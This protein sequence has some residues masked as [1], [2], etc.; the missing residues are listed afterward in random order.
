[1]Q[2]NKSNLRAEVDPQTIDMNANANAN[3]IP[4]ISSPD[5]KISEGSPG[6]GKD[7]KPTKINNMN[8][9]CSDHKSTIYKSCSD[10][11]STAQDINGHLLKA[12]PVQNICNIIQIYSG[13]YILNSQAL[14]MAIH[15]HNTRRSNL[16]RG[17]HGMS[18][19]MMLS[20]LKQRYIDEHYY[21][22]VRALRNQYFFK[23]PKFCEE[24]Q[25]LL[26]IFVHDPQY[27]IC[28]HEYIVILNWTLTVEQIVS[29]LNAK[30]CRSRSILR[31]IH[32]I[33]D[34]ITDSEYNNLLYLAINND[35]NRYSSLIIPLLDLGAIPTLD[36][37][38]KALRHT[39]PHRCVRVLSS[40]KNL[41]QLQIAKL[42]TIF[43]RFSKYP[44]WYPALLN[45]DSRLVF[46]KKLPEIYYTGYHT[47]YQ[48][49][50]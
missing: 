1:M 9:S 27:H 25:K 40:L 4:D 33:K 15:I 29:L 16:L 45:L 28:M 7:N 38:D 42:W 10:H 39:T 50:A 18:I 17:G 35:Y 30:I 46:V 41:T 37:L 26:K 32:S 49:L 3:N 20:A 2:S 44:E 34:S 6:E 24:S 48:P 23:K 31:S 22:L 11:K 43:T 5:G 19:S 47:G 14:R 13:T 8:K 36:T 12:I 21:V